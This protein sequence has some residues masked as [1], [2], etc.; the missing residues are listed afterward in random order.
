[1]LISYAHDDDG[2]CERVRQLWALLRSVG[3]DARLDVLAEVEQ[4]YWPDWMSEQVRFVVVV[5]SPAYRRRAE[6]REEPG[7]GHGVRWEAQAL[8]DLLHANPEAFGRKVAL[9]VL[10]GGS[11]EGFPD[12]M[13]PWGRTRHVVSEFTVAGAESLVRLLTGQPLDVEP[14]LGAAPRLR[15]RPVSA[16]GAA[17]PPLR[18]QLLIR[19]EVRDG[20]VS[21]QVSL[22]GT[23]L[24]ATA[25]VRLPAEVTGVWAS[26]RAGP[27]VAAERMAAAGRT[28]ARA[29]LDEPSGRLVA[30]LAAR[31]R[32]G[33]WVDVVWAGDGEALGLPVE[34]LW[35]TGSDSV[36]LGPVALLG[37]VTVRR[38]VAGALAPAG[39]GGLP[40]PVKVLAAVAAPEETETDNPP[41]DVEAEMQAILD[42]VAGPAG[43][44]GGQA[45]GA[46]GRVLAPDRHGVAR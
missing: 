2:H 17:S 3:V 14:P 45:R 44:H 29:V 33:G 42:A 11:V 7:A 6:S 12:W 23:P 1:V 15:P 25:G 18:T 31:W 21:S 36:D 28:L 39:G 38:E 24:C 26:L 19:A 40:G 30:D 32:P 10:P 9:V 4:P 8:K 41:L 22:A 20:L 5:A 16:L 43:E 34:L 35:L 13:S 37:G 46:R 27:Q